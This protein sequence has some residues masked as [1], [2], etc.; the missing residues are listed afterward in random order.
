MNKYSDKTIYCISPV[1]PLKDVENSSA[2]SNYPSIPYTNEIADN[3]AVTGSSS[4]S[5]DGGLQLTQNSN[6]GITAN[7]S[8]DTVLANNGIYNGHGPTDFGVTDIAIN[9]NNNDPQWCGHEVGLMGLP[10]VV[11]P[12]D[13]NQV[14]ID[15]GLSIL[16]AATIDQSL[17]S[18]RTKKKH[19]KRW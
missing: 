13:D 9:G 10:V 2:S 19:P 7:N 17:K 11:P 5:S 4:S 15:G 16:F 12:T 3:Y 6:N 1:I 18:L 14:P 8:F